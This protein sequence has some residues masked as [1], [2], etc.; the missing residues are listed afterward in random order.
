MGELEAVS[1][2]RTGSAFGRTNPSFPSLRL[3]V[4]SRGKS[5]VRTG[6]RAGSTT[7]NPGTHNRTLRTTV[8]RGSLRSSLAIEPRTGRRTR[9]RP[10]RNGRVNRRGPGAASATANRTAAA[11]SANASLPSGARIRRTPTAARPV[12]VGLGPAYPAVAPRA[13]GT[14]PTYATGPT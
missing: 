13:A 5:R 2:D 10:T 4:H 14:T 7:R 1:T 11:T 6:P 8:G 12:A 3:G 9:R